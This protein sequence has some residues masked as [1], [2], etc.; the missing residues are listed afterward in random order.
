VLN[1]PPPGLDVVDVC[2]GRYLRNSKPFSVFYQRKTSDLLKPKKSPAVT[3]F[4]VA[5]KPGVL[6]NN[7]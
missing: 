5:D 6:L 7:K 3:R 4:V 2:T 1:E